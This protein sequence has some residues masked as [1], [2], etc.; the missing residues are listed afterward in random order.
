MAFSTT[1]S[2]GAD[3]LRATAD[4]QTINALGGNDWLRSTFDASTLYGGNGHDRITLAL[5]P[6]PM[7]AT[8][9][10]ASA[11]LFGGNGNDWLVSDFTGRITE[12]AGFEFNSQQSGGSGDDNISIT[13]FSTSDVWGGAGVFDFEVSGGA[14]S[15]DIWIEVTG[16]D[17]E[18][19]NYVDAGIGSD[20]VYIFTDIG[21]ISG[22]TITEVEA[23]DGDDD[24]LVHGTAG[25]MSGPVENTLFGGEGNDQ[26]EAHASGPY[27][28][29][30]LDGGNGDDVLIAIAEAGNETTSIATN[31]VSGGDGNDTIE[32]YGSSGSLMPSVVHTAYGDGGDDIIT[33]VAQTGVAD[34]GDRTTVDT[35][36][37]GGADDDILTAT[38]IFGPN[39]EGEGGSRLYGRT[40]DDILR[41]YGGVEN[42]LDGGAG[43]D[44]ITGGIG[45]D[46][47]IGGPG[48]DRLRGGG[49]NDAFIFLF[50]D[51][52]TPTPGDTIFDFG[53]GTAARGDDVIDLSRVDA[54]AN[55]AGNQAFVFGGTTQT[56]IGRVWVEENPDTAGSLVMANTGGAE[57]LVIAVE[58]WASRDSSDWVR[59]DFVL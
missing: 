37:D 31:A 48:A 49:G 27:G 21:D 45:A 18:S 25:W 32:L 41:V 43:D 58:D 35:R 54:N 34:D 8:D 46:R 23:G 29:N 7:M 6:P 42:T 19:T 51:G 20:T 4:N 55:V 11:A 3:R 26:L 17:A 50:A 14:G 57:L 30:T 33:S 15:D 52:V 2:D 28:L 47:I 22:N 1:P 9:F 36:L 13:A 40:G 39:D 5:A 12:E 38:T 56:G 24:V 59:G 16:A 10:N 53:I 44:T